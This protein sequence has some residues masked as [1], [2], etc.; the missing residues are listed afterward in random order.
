MLGHGAHGQLDVIAIF[1]TPQLVFIDA[2]LRSPR[3]LTVV[4]QIR[5]SFELMFG[6]GYCE[7]RAG[8]VS[9]GLPA[10]GQLAVASELRADRQ[11]FGGV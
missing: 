3:E 10:V 5:T 2:G 11:R 1:C 9:A 4:A 7:V 6:S 8:R